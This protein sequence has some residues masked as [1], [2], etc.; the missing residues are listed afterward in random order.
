LLR[1]DTR[2]QGG[3]AVAATTGTEIRNVTGP[4]DY[5]FRTWTVVQD[6]DVFPEVGPLRGIT[7]VPD[8]FEGEF[9]AAS[10]NL[11][12]LFDTKDDARTTDPVVTDA[13][14]SVRVE[15]IARA[16]RDVLKRPDIIAVQEAENLDVLRAVALAA[17]GYDAHL[18]EGNDLG[19]IDVGF[20]TRRDR[21]E[22]QSVGQEGRDIRQGN[23]F[24][25]DRPPL[26]LHATVLGVPLT[27]IAVHLRSLLDA[28][29]AT[30]AAKRRGQA[31]GLRDI[32]RQRVSAGEQV[33]VL[34]DFN[35]FEDDPLMAVIRSGGPLTNLTD[36]L[37]PHENYSYVHDGIAQTLDHILLS[38][39]LRER[40]N[41]TQ[42]ARINADYPAAWHGDLARAER[43]SDHDIPVVYLDQQPFTILSAAGVSNAATFL[44]GSIAPGE[45]VSIF[46]R[47][48][49]QSQPWVFFNDQLVRAFYGDANQVNVHV[50]ANLQPGTVALIRVESGGRITN[51]VRV[52]VAAAAPG[53]FGIRGDVLPGNTIE[54]YAT[55]ARPESVLVL[56]GGRPAEVL[57]AGEQGGLLQVNVRVPTG[58]TTDNTTVVLAAGDAVAVR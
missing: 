36:T 1:V 4:L 51:T 17:G 24:L 15:K 29:D 44:G 33:M 47:W 10:M 37:P 52:P 9:V 22:V 38:A 16:I 14:L 53:I 23:G 27:A 40:L 56:I 42:F 41:H 34:G 58:V 32:V 11:Q 21:V 12:R 57:Y 3:R 35:M 6:P 54:I 28:E 48:R 50:P 30:V 20:L 19:G 25:W 45:L 8:S 13:A 2:A 43:Y 26:V 39:G 49:A 18:L 5:A 31:E 55:G 7:A 46:G